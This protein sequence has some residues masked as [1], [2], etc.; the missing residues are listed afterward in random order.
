MTGG[1]LLMAFVH[2]QDRMGHT[3]QL[4]SHTYPLLLNDMVG[5]DMD[6]KGWVLIF[7]G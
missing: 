7:R 2:L 4:T 6:E 1:E 5:R 3:L